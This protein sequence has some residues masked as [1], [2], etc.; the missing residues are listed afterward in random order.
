MG[1]LVKLFVQGMCMNCMQFYI[2][3]IL[4]WC[5][6]S[7]HADKPIDCYDLIHTDTSVNNILVNDEWAWDEDLPKPVEHRTEKVESTFIQKSYEYIK[8]R[9]FRAALQLLMF[10]HDAHAYVAHLYRS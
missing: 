6:H 2:L 5:M 7:L 3:I 4:S 10:W 9:A 1:I 8:V